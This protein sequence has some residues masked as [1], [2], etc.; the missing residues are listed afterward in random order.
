MFER[1]SRQRP[2]DRVPAAERPIAVV[3]E[4]ARADP[5]VGRLYDLLHEVIDPEIGINIID[6]GLV[7]D[8]TLIDRLATVQM[9][10]TT[11]GCPLSGYMDSAIRHAL[12]RLP[13]ID[14]TRVDLVWDPPWGPHQMT[15]E[16]KRQL[17]WVP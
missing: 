4:P 2:G 3:P 11:P 10:L 17:G 7:F 13:E 16:A 9:T 12:T 5:A 15:E 6:L 14:D 8:V 1:R